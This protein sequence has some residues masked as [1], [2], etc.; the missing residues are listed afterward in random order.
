MNILLINHYAGSPEMGMEFRPYYFAREWIKLG[1]KVDIIAADFSHLRRKNPDV[2]KDWQK[3]EIGGITYHW[4]KTGSYDGNGV[5][6]AL[7]MERFVRKIREYSGWLIREISPD[8]VICSSTYPLDTY[9]GQKLRS[10]AVHMGSKRPVLVQEVH[11]M[12]PSTLIEIG[13]MSKTN[14]FVLVMQAAENS[15]YRNSDRV[16]AMAPYSEPY[17]TEHGLKPGKFTHIPLGIDFSEWEDSQE[18]DEEHRRSIEAH[19]EKYPFLLGYFGGHALSNALDTLIDT[20][21]LSKDKGLPFGFVLV[22]SGVE[23]AGLMER[24]AREHLD[25]VIFLPPVPKTQIPALTACFDALYIGVKSSPLYE[26][27]GL[28]MNKMADAMMA[29]RPVICSIG[30]PSTWITESGCGITV[31]PED[32]G[33]I[34]E[35]ME[36]V[37][38]MS[39]GEKKAM[40]ERG[41][42]YCENNLEVGYLARKMLD[43]I[44]GSAL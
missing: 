36:K 16:I 19:R 29:S 20:A 41:R 26:K 18:L 39:A 32:P 10:M 14:P 44:T 31:P 37:Y 11:D 4:V 23:K 38:H 35:A 17:M 3:E 30:A 5:A 12:W 6:R 7:T 22:G 42:E 8:V 34:L 2:A 13:G 1:H 21:A 9:A 27:F 28:C 33:A 15:A 25:S 24:A 40:G 43:A